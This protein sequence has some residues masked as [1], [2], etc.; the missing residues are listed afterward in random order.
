MYVQKM[1]FRMNCSL[2]YY[3]VVCIEKENYTSL[4]GL[5]LAFLDLSGIF[6]LL[7]IIGFQGIGKSSKP[8]SG[9]TATANGEQIT[10]K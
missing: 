8:G 9:E 5:L 2:G 7:L 6:D 4:M 10:K 1:K 3:H